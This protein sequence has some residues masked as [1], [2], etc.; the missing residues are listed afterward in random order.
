MAKVDII[1]M[2][3]LMVNLGDAYFKALLPVGKK[4]KIEEAIKEDIKRAKE[5]LNKAVKL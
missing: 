4:E 2:N 5:I 1:L 3:D